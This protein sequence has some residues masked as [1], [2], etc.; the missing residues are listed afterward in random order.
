MTHRFFAA[1]ALV[2]LMLTPAFVRTARAQDAAT[3]ASNVQLDLAPV[4]AAAPAPAAAQ[5]TSA[6]P[7]AMRRAPHISSVMTSLY[8]TTAAMQMMDVRSTLSAFRNG[9]TEA[10]PMM[11]AI[12]KNKGAFIAFKAGIAMSTIWSAHSM[13]KRNK[14]GAILMLAAVNSAYAMV[15]NHNYQVARSLAH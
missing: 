2:A 1:A 8:A 5:F 11:M 15:V 10:N 7:A 3:P 14:V 9:A 4:V 6:L 12:V 13:A